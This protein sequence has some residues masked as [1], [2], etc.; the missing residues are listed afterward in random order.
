MIEET[1]KHRFG[2]ETFRPLQRE[3]VEASLAGADILA[4][5]PTGGGKSLCYQLPAVMRPGLTLVPPQPGFYRLDSPKEIGFYPVHL[6][7]EALCFF[8]SV[9]H[10]LVIDLPCSELFIFPHCLSHFALPSAG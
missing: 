5:L 2:H 3:I 8:P 6:G 9:E 10:D 7:G 1:L 4:L